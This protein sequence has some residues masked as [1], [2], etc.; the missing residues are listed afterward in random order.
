MVDGLMCKT[1][2]LE[3][4]Q[5]LAAATPNCPYEYKITRRSR[6]SP[7][8]TRSV[9]A[10]AMAYILPITHFVKLILCTNS[11]SI[12]LWFLN[13]KGNNDCTTRISTT[14]ELDN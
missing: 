13:N 8:F 7:G 2:W 12:V 14:L 3:L 5:S 1:K 4:I 9:D 11:H 6:Y 10:A